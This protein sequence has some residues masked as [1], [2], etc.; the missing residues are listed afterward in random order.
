MFVWQELLVPELQ[1]CQNHASSPVFLEEI[2]ARIRNEGSCRGMHGDVLLT[3]GQKTSGAEHRVAKASRKA[4]NGTKSPFRFSVKLP[5]CLFACLPSL[6]TLPSPR[7][8]LPGV[9]LAV[10]AC[11]HPQNFWGCG[12]LLLRATILKGG[13]V[14]RGGEKDECS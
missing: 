10:P 14:W 5:G 7:R 8:P 1:T 11:G 13:Q 12:W 3:A 2:H 6:P 9:L 4:G